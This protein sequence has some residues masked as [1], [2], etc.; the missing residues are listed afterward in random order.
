MLPAYN[1][2]M[3]RILRLAGVSLLFMA[4][5]VLAFASKGGGEKKK[6]TAFEDRFTPIDAAS[7]FTLKKMPVYSGTL[8][9]FR[10]QADNRISMQAM[11]TYQQ[12]NTTFILPYQYKVKIGPVTSSDG[13]TNLQ[14]LGVKIQMPTK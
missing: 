10:P 4:V 6:H 12:G 2:S 5:T 7:S 3:L 13:K 9:N 1:Q 14:F 8:M 11:I